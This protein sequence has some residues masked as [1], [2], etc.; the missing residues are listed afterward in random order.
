MR[1]FC[2]RAF[3]SRGAP[4][5]L[6][7]PCEKTPLRDCNAL[8]Q[9]R[10]RHVTFLLRRMQMDRSK[11]SRSLIRED[12]EADQPALPSFFVSVVVTGSCSCFTSVCRLN[13]HVGT[14]DNDSRVIAGSGDRNGR[15]GV[16]DS[17]SVCVCAPHPP[18][19]WGSV[20]KLTRCMGK[21]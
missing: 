9:S 17:V 5:A 1:T 18:T 7:A 3:E 6:K 21:D 14:Q 10:A 4:C 16:K 20:S 13:N 8:K 15:N 12:A 2:S 19:K 11:V